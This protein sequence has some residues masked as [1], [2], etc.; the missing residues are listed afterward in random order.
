ME[1]LVG[2]S[3]LR[4]K[5]GGKLL[6]VCFAVVSAEQEQTQQLLLGDVGVFL[7]QGTQF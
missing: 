5:L 2:R 1:G 7:S 4:H 6:S 3:T